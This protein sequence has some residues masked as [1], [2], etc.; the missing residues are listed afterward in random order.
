[1]V[2]SSTVNK[3]VL[4]LNFAIFI[5][6]FCINLDFKKHCLKILLTLIIEHFWCPC[7][8]CIPGRYLTCC[9]PSRFSRVWLFVILWTVAHQAPLSM[10]FSTQEYWSGLPG[11]PPGDLPD[12]GIEPT[13]LMSPAL[14][15]FFFTTSATWEAHPSACVSKREFHLSIKVPFYFFSKKKLSPFIFI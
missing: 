7:K 9:V 5:I 12:P 11:P 13:F 15:G 1:M 3:S 10:G 8:F 14:A 6:I 4:I 2:P